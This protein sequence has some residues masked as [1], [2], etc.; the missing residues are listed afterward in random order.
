MSVSTSDRVV[1]I[2]TGNICR[3]AYAERLARLRADQFGLAGW[4]FASAGIGA[5]VGSPMEELM[6]QQLRSRGGDPAGFVSRQLNRSI[7]QD[8][9]LILPMEKFQRQVV[10][11]E[12]PAL[13]RRVHT[14]GKLAED[15]QSLPH[16]VVGEAYLAALQADR[17]PTRSQY[18]VTDPFRKG[19]ERAAEVADLLDH[20][21]TRIIARL[22][23]ARQEH[24]G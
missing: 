5:L 21:V 8:A 13:V 19:P 12:Y 16:E 2:C 10:L 4:T 6:A 11:G 15:D 14:V 18:D 20:H 1:F 9:T 17:R 24:A 23:G 22:A 7:V 3:S